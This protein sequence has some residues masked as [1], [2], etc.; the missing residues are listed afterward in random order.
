VHVISVSAGE[1]VVAR[2][3]DDDVVAVFRGDKRIEAITWLTEMASSS[4]LPVTP[5]A[6]TDGL[7]SEAPEAGG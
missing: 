1:D 6:L 5:V 2:P 4:S 3:A 7:S